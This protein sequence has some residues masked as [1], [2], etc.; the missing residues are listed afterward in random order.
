SEN[1]LRSYR[2]GEGR[3]SPSLVRSLFRLVAADVASFPARSGF[4]SFPFSLTRENVAG[5]I[6]T[7]ELRNSAR[8]VQTA[9]FTFPP[10]TR[11]LPDVCS[12]IA[13]RRENFKVGSIPLGSQSLYIAKLEHMKLSAPDETGDEA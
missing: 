8:F 13:Q 11:S 12:G 9:R 10:L 6:R 5:Q 4:P 1:I 2:S 3:T 7:V